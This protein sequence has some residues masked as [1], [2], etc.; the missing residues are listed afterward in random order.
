M[1]PPEQKVYAKKY[2]AAGTVTKESPSGRGIPWIIL[3]T[4]LFVTMD[5]MIKVLLSDGYSLVQVVWARYF[6]HVLLLVIILLPR[7]QKISQSENFKLQLFRSIL[8][9]LTT[10]LF[11]AGLQYVPLA[12]ASSMMLISPLIVTA[13]AMPILK[14][15]VGARRWVSIFIGFFG[16]LIIIRPGSALM[17]I[18]ILLPAAAAVSYAVYQI[19]TR[20]LSQEDSTLTTL[21]YTALVGALFTSIAT[22][23]YWIQPSSFA[24]MLMF[25]AGFCGG[26]GHFALIKAFTLSPAS[27]ISPYGYLNMIWAILFGFV[28]FAELPDSWTIAGAAII[29][30]S[31]LYVYH[32]ERRLKLN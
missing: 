11:F 9:L 26:F 8:M 15:P 23:F 4:F 28:L 19:S 25:G 22:P 5:A 29:T 27:V 3:A 31:G 13:L 21:F 12:E 17:S 7:I 6:F 2:T 32:R 1:S 14:E 16:A 18:G 30:G 24:W 10:S 20:L